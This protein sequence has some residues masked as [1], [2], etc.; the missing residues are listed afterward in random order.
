MGGPLRGAP[1]TYLP[2]P[3]AAL[4]M[5][6]P[7]KPLPADPLA[8]LQVAQAAGQA[9][10]PADVLALLQAIVATQRE[11]LEGQ[12]AIL[13]ALGTRQAAA[14]GGENYG[15]LL[16]AIYPHT[17]HGT[18]SGR[19]LVALATE[20]ANEVLRTVIVKTVGELNARK[21]GK[22]LARIDGREFDGLRVEYVGDERD[23][24]IWLVRVCGFANAQTHLA[25]GA[26]PEPR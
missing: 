4:G 1:T 10:A 15:P 14:S 8:A 24:A 5:G 19:Q 2:T 13:S 12:R 7:C 9:P 17:Q 22:L 21:L 23:G 6:K 26:T 20:P 11:L 25:P 3:W 16:L 18:F